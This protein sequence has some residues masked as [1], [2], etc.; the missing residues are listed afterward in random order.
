M[1]NKL[2]DGFIDSVERNRLQVYGI[3]VLKNGEKIAEK[4]WA[5]EIRHNQ[6]SV[7]K[8][9]TS[10]AIGIAIGEGL[11]SLDD[12]VLDYFSEE[13]PRESQEELQ[14]LTLR[15]LLTMSLGQGESVL[16]GDQRPFL[17]E[18]NWVRHAL[19]QSFVHKPGE[20]F[21][22]T[23]A[24]PY[25]AAVMLQKKAGQNLVDYLMPRL[26]EPLGI[27]RPEWEKCPMGYVFGASGLMINTS[28]LSKL[29]QLYLQKGFWDGKQL[30]PENWIKEATCKQ[31]ATPGDGDW[32][33]G[34]GYQ[35]WRCKP[36]AYRADGM[37]SQF[38]IVIDEK[39]SVITIN[40][41]EERSKLILE[42]VWKDLLPLI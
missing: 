22:Y 31:I 8:S 35:F 30:V 40:S 18:K 3:I 23:N 2:L 12:K 41:N 14:S 11:L 17:K 34:Y 21:L 15:H 42:S 38:C 10:T 36:N 29:G 33:E 4:R 27:D 32:G 13:A 20:R 1:N 39:Q 24:G 7:S 26:F 16:M 9:F 25:L 5:E 28:E 6:Y 19:N 37:Y